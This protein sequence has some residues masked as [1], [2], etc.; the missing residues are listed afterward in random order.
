MNTPTRTPSI[1]ATHGH[2]LSLDETARVLGLSRR[3]AMRQLRAGT[4]PVPALPRLGHA[5]WRF[6]AVHIDRYLARATDG[7]T[8]GIR[9]V[10]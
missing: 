4:F 9:R 10:S 3:S 2:T 8:Q 5:R 7:V 1:V 6:A